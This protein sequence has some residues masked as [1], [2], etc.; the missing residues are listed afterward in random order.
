[1]EV[2][3]A[4]AAEG[5]EVEEEEVVEMEEEEEAAAAAAEEEEEVEVVVG[6]VVVA[7]QEQGLATISDSVPSV[8][9][10]DTV[11]RALVHVPDMETRFHHHP[12]Q[13]F[14]ELLCLEKMIHI[15][16]FAAL[17]VT[18]DTVPR[19]HVG[20]SES[21]DLCE[22]EAKP[23]S[24]LAHSINEKFNNFGCFLFFLET[25][26]LLLQSGIFVVY[27]VCHFSLK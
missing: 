18:M 23:P 12:L 22:P 1:M 19:Q 2:V 9:I 26:L 5:E 17:P 6:A 15:W 24:S 11:L 21:I 20:H 8:A 13:V 14:G 3:A 16:V 7:F 4:A 27:L 25:Y 10:L